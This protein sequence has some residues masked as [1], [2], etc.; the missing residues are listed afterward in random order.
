MSAVF[1][2]VTFAHGSVKYVH[3]KFISCS[4]DVVRQGCNYTDSLG[5]RSGR[6]MEWRKMRISNFGY[7]VD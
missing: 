7:L 1:L 2:F 6:R 5:G 4:G 3:Y